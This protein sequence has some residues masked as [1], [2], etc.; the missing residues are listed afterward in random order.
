LIG[1]VSSFLVVYH[2][3]S[4]TSHFVFLPLLNENNYHLLS[5]VYLSHLSGVHDHILTFSS[6]D[7]KSVPVNPRLSFFF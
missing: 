1:F 2:T 7:E 3:L 5:N 4:L 6:Q